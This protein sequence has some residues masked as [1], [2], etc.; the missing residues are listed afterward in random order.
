[1]TVAPSQRSLISTILQSDLS[2]NPIFQAA[3]LV[4]RVVVGSLMI[5]NGFSKL[6]DVPGFIEHVINVIGLPFPTFFTYLAAY[7]EIVA[8]IFLIA[9]LLTRFSAL[10]LLFTML[11]AVYFHLKDSGFQIP[12]LETASV[13]SLCY[14]ALAAGGGGNLSIDH[15]L[16][17][18][19]NKQ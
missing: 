5:H 7:T 1:M 16:V 6:A 12:P 11:I 10:S 2:P 8:S 9:G 17:K 14:L 13:Y 3:W 19:F 18:I 4:V 15:F